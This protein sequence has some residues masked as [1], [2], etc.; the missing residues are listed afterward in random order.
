MLTCIYLIFDISVSADQVTVT[1]TGAEGIS[2]S[3]SSLLA[4]LGSNGSW[5]RTIDGKTMQVQVLSINGPY[6]RV[7]I[8]ESGGACSP[9]PL[10]T[11]APTLPPGSPPAV[12]TNEL[13]TTFAN[14]NGSIG[15]FFKVSAAGTDLD[16]T[17]FSVH[18]SN[19][20]F[21]TVKVWTR[22]GDDYASF[23]TNSAAWTEI[24]NQQV[25]GLGRSQVTQLPKFNQKINVQAGTYRCFYV[26]VSGGIRYTNGSGEGN[27]YANNAGEL[28]FYEGKG[29]GGQFSSST[30]SPRVWNG[31]IE[32]EMAT[33]GPVLPPT[34]LPTNA[35][36]TANVS[37]SLS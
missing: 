32:Y 3:E 18:T 13:S 17:R 29:S 4:K 27:V 22:E 5:S 31:I 21:Q 24:F 35:P 37:Y 9:T 2:R 6:A 34:P 23:T 11:P 1:E 7:R 20:G 25:N 14:G 12:T 8:S 36:S 19:T 28:T 30:W 33:S 26:T 15:N 10:P 16:I